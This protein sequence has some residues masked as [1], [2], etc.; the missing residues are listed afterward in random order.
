LTYNGTSWSAAT[1]IDGN[2]TI[3]AV[4]C[5]SSSFCAAVDSRGNVV[6]YNGTSW[7]S[8]SSIDSARKIESI[9]CSTST[10]C[11]AVDSQGYVTIYM[12]APTNTSWLIWDTNR[13]LPLVLSDGTTDYIYGPGSTPVEQVSLASSTPTFMTYVAS[14]ASWLITTVAGQEIAFYGYDAFGNMTFGT[15][16]SSFGFAGEYTDSTTGFSNLRARWYTPQTGT[17]L[18]VDPAV[19][20]TDEPYEYASDDPV[21]E[22]D[23]LGLWGLNPISD[24]TEAA[25]DVGHAV[26]HHWRGIVQVATVVASGLGSA[27]CIAA[28]DGLCALALPE[29]GSA[30]AAAVYGE[31]GGQHTLGGYLSAAAEGGIGGGVALICAAGVCEVAGS[32]AAGGVLVNGLW[33][34]GQGIWDYANSDVCHTAGGYV[35]A[36]ENGF[37]QGGVPWDEIWQFLRGGE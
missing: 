23:P 9:S 3:D 1:S 36:G 33:G 21:N 34:A 37:L 29:I 26:Q 4:S 19:M 8:T 31:G 27:A 15:P 16:G 18:T 24:V 11:T 13:Q 28:T 6:T 25:S 30:T 12:S 17:F 2:N 14:G 22:E 5:V 20:Q 35:S 7:S 32:V 10:S